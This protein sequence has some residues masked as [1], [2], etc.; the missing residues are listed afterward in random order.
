M[1]KQLLITPFLKTPDFGII[2][3]GLNHDSTL[4]LTKDKYMN[5]IH[6]E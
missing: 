4:D 2:I 1:L 6:I 5:L 3:K